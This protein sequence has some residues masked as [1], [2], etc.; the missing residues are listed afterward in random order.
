MAK[1]CGVPGKILKKKT[2]KFKDINELGYK[3]F[4]KDKANLYYFET[5][6]LIYTID[7]N[8]FSLHINLSIFH[9][10]SKKRFQF[11]LDKLKW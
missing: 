3:E 7:K 2:A 11:M 10:I 8:C 4:N 6:I 1:C 9:L 5:C